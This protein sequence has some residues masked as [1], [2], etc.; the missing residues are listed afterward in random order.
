MLHG[1]C[2]FDG[3]DLDLTA[4]EI[5]H[6]CCKEAW[7]R[8]WCVFWRLITHLYIATKLGSRLGFKRLRRSV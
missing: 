4:I 1:N 7:F 5:L 2:R 3:G 6:D 8:S